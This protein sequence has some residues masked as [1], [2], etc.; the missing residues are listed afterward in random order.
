M[1]VL[2]FLT[3]L[4]S[5]VEIGWKLFNLGQKNWFSGFSG[6]RYDVIEGS[7]SGQKTLKCVF[8]YS[9][10]FWKVLL[11]S[12][13]N[14]PIW[15]KKLFF[16]GFS[17][18]RYDVKEG[19]DS[20]QNTPKCVFLYSKHFWKVWLNRMKNVRFRSKIGRW[21][22]GFLDPQNDCIMRSE[23]SKIF[24]IKKFRPKLYLILFE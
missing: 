11:K 4:E 3:L 14:C 2:I 13:E 1:C 18:P 9:K 6:P 12:C 8:L 5:F 10:H 20:G 22:L 23:G 19:S 17:D 21:F 15:Y 24:F 7:D 16:S